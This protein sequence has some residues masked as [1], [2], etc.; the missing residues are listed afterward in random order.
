[1]YSEY[2]SEKPPEANEISMGPFHLFAIIDGHRGSQVAEF[3]K[4]HLMDVILRNENI[5]VKRYFSIGLK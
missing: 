2:E 4:N 5:M 3:I 1:M